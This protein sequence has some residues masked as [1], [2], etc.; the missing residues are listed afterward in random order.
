MVTKKHYKK[1]KISST[2]ST[3]STKQY[4]S[5]S[6]LSQTRPFQSLSQDTVK[7]MQLITLDPNYPPDL[8]G[9]FKYAIHEY[10]ADID[11]FENYNACCSL[12]TAKTEIATKF[13]QMAKRIIENKQH[14][15]LG[16]F[17]AGY[18]DRYYVDIGKVDNNE[19]VY[20]NPDKI[21][22]RLYELKKDDLLTK[23]EYDELLA[24]VVKNPKLQQ[25]FDLD[26]Q[27]KKKYVVRWKIDEMVKGEKTLHLGKEITLEDALAQQSI[28]KIDI[29]IYLNNRYQEHILQLH[30]ES[31]QLKNQPRYLVLMLLPMLL[32]HCM[33]YE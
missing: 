15:Y 30:L 17:K 10:P 21:K 22:E 8:V 2:K 1:N 24:K 13:K 19:I 14:I 12:K 32:Y 6:A 18:D 5:N 31:V 3:K 9:S 7:C 23:K 28:V 11:M 16:D 27:I 4:I 20:Y 25:Y 33:E 26:S 29:W